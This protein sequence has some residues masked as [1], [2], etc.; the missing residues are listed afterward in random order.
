MVNDQDRASI[1]HDGL[2]TPAMTCM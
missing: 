1:P 2:C